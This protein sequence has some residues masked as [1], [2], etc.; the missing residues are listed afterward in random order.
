MCVLEMIENYEQSCGVSDTHSA[1]PNSPRTE[2]EE[3]EARKKEG[4]EQKE[5]EDEET[6]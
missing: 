3:E 1:F 6:T 5:E 4:E 2:E